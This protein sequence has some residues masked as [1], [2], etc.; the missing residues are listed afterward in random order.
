MASGTQQGNGDQSERESQNDNAERL[1]NAL[2]WF[3][4]GLGLAEMAAPSA[5]AQ[6]IGVTDEDKTRNVLRG[7]GLREIAAGIGILSRPQPAGWLWGRVAGDLLDLSSLGT[8][9][10]SSRSNRARVGAATAAV[11]GVTALDVRCALQLHRGSANGGNVKTGDVRVIRTIILNRSPEEVYR[12]WHDFANLPTFMKHLESVEIT[13]DNRSHWKATGPGGKTVEWDAEIVEDQ[14]N[15][16]IAWRSLE[17]SD[18]DNSGSVQFERAPGGRG[19]LVR[20]ELR[21]APPGGVVSATIA[22]LFGE[23]PGQQVDD[24]LRAFKQVLETGEVVKSDA[25]IHRGMHPAQPPTGQE[26]AYAAAG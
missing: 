8:A 7:Y 2:G 26:S 17:G 12:F 16:R 1:A 9:L 13:G 21:Y 19:T 14:P 4:I 20:V 6:L 3:S 10:S 18:I 22:K 25:S 23:E 5:V 11:I 24:D 15:T